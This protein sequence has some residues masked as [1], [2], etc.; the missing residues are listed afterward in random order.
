[1]HKFKTKIKITGKLKLTSTLNK[2]KL[3]LTST[4]NKGKLKLKLTVTYHIIDHSSTY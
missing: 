3:K 1:M 2:G 4:L